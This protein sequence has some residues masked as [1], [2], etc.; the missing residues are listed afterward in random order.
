MKRRKT[1]SKSEILAALKTSGGALSH[2]MLQ[3]TLGTTIDRA[4]IYRVLNRFC[5]DGMV[6]RII[7]DDGKQ[8]FAIC[9]NCGEKKEMHTHNHVHFRCMKCGK[10]EC[11]KS[12]PEIDLPKGY[13]AKMFNMVISG[14]C[15]DCTLI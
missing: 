10:V 14:V 9:E 8:Y 7:G 12:T 3:S 13:Q 2:D 11:L 15:G 5:E 4:T 6:H 1:Q